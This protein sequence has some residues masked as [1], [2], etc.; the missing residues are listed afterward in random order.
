[1]VN[2]GIVIDEGE[3]IAVIETRMIGPDVADARSVELIEGELERQLSEADTWI[4][5]L[6]AEL[7][8]ANNA[9]ETAE[10][11]A[12][13][14]STKIAEF[15]LA[16]KAAEARAEAAEKKA[17]GWTNRCQEV[18][19]QLDSQSYL[20]MKLDLEKAEARAADLAKA[21]E[22]ISDWPFDVRGDCVADARKL[23]FAALNPDTRQEEKENTDAKQS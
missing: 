17:E 18:M 3:V 16:A 5:E 6:K 15:E 20:F 23:A 1:M 19:A 8:E 9:K 12:Y 2:R 7:A 21:L 11:A 10:C 13:Q 14:Y 22:T 4:T